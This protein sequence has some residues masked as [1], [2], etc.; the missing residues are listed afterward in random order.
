[1]CC[2]PLE[3]EGR[4]KDRGRRIGIL[5]PLFDDY[6]MMVE[7]K[8]RAMILKRKMCEDNSEKNKGPWIKSFLYPRSLLQSPLRLELRLYCPVAPMPDT[9]ELEKQSHLEIP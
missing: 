9:P 5:M 6:F 3:K 2:Q 4:N 1:M 8:K 7:K